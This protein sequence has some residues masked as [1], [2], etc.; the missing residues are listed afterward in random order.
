MM[1]RFIDV[2]LEI[3]KFFPCLR[4]LMT[5]LKQLKHCKKVI[6]LQYNCLNTELLQNVRSF[7]EVELNL[8]ENFGDTI[9]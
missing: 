8:G 3:A 6:K 4:K 1:L 9:I 7:K 5:C 2:C